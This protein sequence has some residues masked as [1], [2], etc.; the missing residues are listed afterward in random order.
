VTVTVAVPLRKPAVARTVAAW[1]CD[2][3]LGARY[4]PVRLML[5]TPLLTAQVKLGWMTST[6]PNW[7]RST[8]Q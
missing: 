8:A 4:N 1:P 5:P 3:V 6:L 2:L 7:S